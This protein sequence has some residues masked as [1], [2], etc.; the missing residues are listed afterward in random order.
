MECRAGQIE[1]EIEEKKKSNIG[2][3][4]VAREVCRIASI[5]MA[6]SILD[7]MRKIDLGVKQKQNS[8]RGRYGRE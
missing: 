3:D 7:K 1:N 6:R 2:L 4:E 8:D 5:I